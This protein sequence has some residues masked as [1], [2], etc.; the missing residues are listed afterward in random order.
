MITVDAKSIFFWSYSMLALSLIW[1]VVFLT[2]TD[3]PVSA[4]WPA[5]SEIDFMLMILRSAGTQS[6]VL[7]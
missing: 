2:E 6:P 5:C 4:A 1:S 7:T 3:S